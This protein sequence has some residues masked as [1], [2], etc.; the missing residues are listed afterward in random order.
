M[1]LS[2]RLG[3]LCLLAA[4]PLAAQNVPNLQAIRPMVEA[5]AADAIVLDWKA[6]H[7]KAMA[8]NRQ[9]RDE[10]TGLRAQLD[11]WTSKGGAL[12]HAYCETPGLSRNSAGA[13]N[14][15]TTSGYTC[16]PV[17]GLCRTSAANSSECAA[18]YLWCVNGNR[19][20]ANTAICQ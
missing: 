7:D 20:I 18:G 15:C 17:S 9:L 8:K 10:N 19:C 13:S 2:M 14:D 1:S 12:V 3:L 4:A 5:H 6:E 16:E 11:A